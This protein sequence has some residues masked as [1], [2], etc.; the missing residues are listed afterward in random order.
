MQELINNPNRFD[1]FE[2]LTEEA[3]VLVHER[4]KLL[5][6]CANNPEVQAAVIKLCKE[7]TPDGLPGYLFFARYFACI[8]EPRNPPEYKKLPFVPYEY[9]IRELGVIHDSVQAGLGI[10]GEK[11]ITL[12]LKSRDM[13]M[14]WLVLLYFLWDWIFFGSSFIVG[15]YKGDEVEKAGNPKT[16]FAKMEFLLYN[17]PKWMQ[18]A[19]LVDNKFVLSYNNGESAISGDTCNPDFGAGDRRKAALLDEYSRWEC[20]YEAFQSISQSTNTILLVG[21]PQGYGNHYAQI[22]QGEDKDI[23]ADVRTVHWVEHPLKSRGLEYVNNRPT[24]PWYRNQCRTFSKDVIAAELDL[25]FE[26]STKGIVFDGIYGVGHQRPGLKG[27]PGQRILRI[28]DPGSR[29]FAVLFLQVDERMRARALKEMIFWGNDARI[30]NVAQRV[31]SESGRLGSLYECEFHDTGDPAGSYVGNS[32]QEDP[33]WTILKRD[34]GIH[35]DYRMFAEMPTKNRRKSRI[36]I[37]ERQ[38]QQYISH[39]VPELDGP[40]LLIDTDEC[41]Q[42]NR[43]FLGGYKYKT[44]AAGNVLEDIDERHPFEDVMDD[45]GYGLLYEIGLPEDLP[46]SQQEQYTEEQLEDMQ[47]GN[48]YVDLSQKR[49]RRC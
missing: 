49:W 22:A 34:F 43:A 18:P 2:F 4:A 7:G 30:Q 35:V 41:P 17:L 26:G 32:A 46:V 16:L 42:L 23:T 31:L 29:C 21:T 14:T 10:L 48:P 19:G 38:L 1:D 44:D 13:G 15:S 33:E 12:W 47:A 8:F 28:W 39:T 20:D 45:L 27:V 25:S 37:I 9:Q 40:A 3:K 11:S 6:R 24:S 5:I 36:K